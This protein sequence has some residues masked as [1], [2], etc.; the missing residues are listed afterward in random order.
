M[1]GKEEPGL[2]AFLVVEGRVFDLF[3]ERDNGIG[4]DRPRAVQVFCPGNAQGSFYSAL[5]C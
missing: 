2:V 4:V 1:I 3:F 5:S